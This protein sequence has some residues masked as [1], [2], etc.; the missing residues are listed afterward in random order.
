MKTHSRVDRVAVEIRDAIA[1]AL[2]TDANDPRLARVNVTDVRV[3]GDLQHARVFW[4]LVDVDGGSQRERDRTGRALERAI[5]FLRSTI[6]RD[7]ALRV[8]PELTFTFDASLERGRRIESILR[9]VLPD[10][11]QAAPETAAVDADESD[12]DDD[13]GADDEPRAPGDIGDV[14]P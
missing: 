9:D 12:A 11:E 14:E 5:G 4:T 1:S 10:G 7:V 13:N 6:A 3:S 8:V 2:L